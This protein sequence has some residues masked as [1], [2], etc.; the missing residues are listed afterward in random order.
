MNLRLT[1]AVG[2]EAE[3]PRYLEKG[4]DESGVK[5]ASVRDALGSVIANLE[6]VSLLVLSLFLYFFYSHFL[7]LGL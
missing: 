7:V 4:R 2:R 3:G 5:A 1:G 6:A